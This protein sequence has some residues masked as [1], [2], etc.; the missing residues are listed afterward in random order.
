MVY[1]DGIY[2]TD[3]IKYFII[4]IY[5]TLPQTSTLLQLNLVNIILFDSPAYKS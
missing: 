4:L 1:H 5:M 2:Y 3:G